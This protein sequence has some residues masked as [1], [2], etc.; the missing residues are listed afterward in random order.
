[1]LSYID[2]VTTWKFRLTLFI[3]N[4]TSVVSQSTLSG[5]IGLPET[6]GILDISEII[7]YFLGD[8]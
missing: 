3:W 4:V 7:N 6:V 8:D 5:L 2:K 1:M